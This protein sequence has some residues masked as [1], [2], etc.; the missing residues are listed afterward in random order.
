MQPGILL[1][2]ASAVLF[3]ASTP[4]AKLLLGSVDPWLMAGLLYLGA[5]L[6]LAVVHISRR[7]L[8]LPA[9]EAPL[10][11]ADVP[12]L[13]L[14]WV[15]RVRARKRHP[16]DQWRCGCAGG[17]VCRHERSRDADAALRWHDAVS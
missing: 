12:W 17:A 2:L 11:R 4:F 16:L 13:A 8:R 6:G 10:R 5:G 3:G 1:A 9:A 14:G 15:S 7:V